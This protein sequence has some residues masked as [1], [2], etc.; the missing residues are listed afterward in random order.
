MR[1]LRRRRPHPRGASRPQP[2]HRA[3]DRALRGGGGLG[4]GPGDPPGAPLEATNW[5]VEIACVA[6]PV[7]MDTPA[8][9]AGDPRKG[10]R[11]VYFPESGGFI[12]CPVYDRYRLGV[13]AALAGPA[14]IEERE[15]TAVL[16]PGDHAT[17]DAHG[18]LIIDVAGG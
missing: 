5:K 6:P 8:R 4:A 17:V 13:G 11:R 10:V 16:L 2:G 15:T 18:N 1:D 12:D 7:V 9:G 14:V 3:G